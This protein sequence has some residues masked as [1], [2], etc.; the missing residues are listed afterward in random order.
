[1]PLPGHIDRLRQERNTPGAC[2]LWL[3]PVDGVAV[4]PAETNGAIPVDTPVVLAAGYQWTE[5]TPTVATQDFSEDWTRENGARKAHASLEWEVA[6]DR[7]QLLE[8][9]WS[10][11][12]MRC[13]VQHRDANGATKLMGTKAEPALVVVTEI[14]HGTRPGQGKNRYLLRASV[15]RGTKC[16]VYL[17]ASVP[18][19]PPVPPGCPTLGQ[20]VPAA[21]ASTINALLT[22]AQQLWFA[23]YYGMPAPCP[24]LAE[25]LAQVP[26]DQLLSYLTGEQVAALTEQLGSDIDFIDGGE[27]GST[28][29]DDVDP[30][31][32]PTVADFEAADFSPNDYM[33]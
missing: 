7:L 27:P 10:L 24:G 4:M 12:R 33:T 1:M 22:P 32:E 18:Q 31:D 2:G 6:K 28:Y 20:L 8:P 16:P 11:G 21:P 14:T 19:A 30:G 23:Q 15:S 17:P 9:L 25:L 29:A 3:V 26:G 13:L 5:I